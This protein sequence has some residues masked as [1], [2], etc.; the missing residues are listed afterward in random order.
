MGGKRPAET[1][2]DPYDIDASRPL[3]KAIVAKVIT[4][5]ATRLTARMPGTSSIV[6]TWAPPSGDTGRGLR[7][8]LDRV[9]R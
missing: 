1:L 2:A 3:P 8:L 4:E 9:R 5:E 7:D 6:L